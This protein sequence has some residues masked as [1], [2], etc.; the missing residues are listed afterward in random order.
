MI[1]PSPLV[2]SVWSGL[3]YVLRLPPFST[4]SLS[5]VDYTVEFARDTP[6]WGQSCSHLHR[7]LGSVYGICLGGRREWRCCWQKGRWDKEKEEEEGKKISADRMERPIM[8][9]YL[10][11][12]ISNGRQ[13]PGQ[14]QRPQRRPQ[15]RQRQRQQR[16]LMRSYIND[17]KATSNQN[18]SQYVQSRDGR[19]EER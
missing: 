17:Q 14:Q 15:Q 6:R 4:T 7:T 8:R 12:D 2:S 13:W 1:I 19:D 10:Y 16:V 9:R 18:W 11:K 5:D 3:H